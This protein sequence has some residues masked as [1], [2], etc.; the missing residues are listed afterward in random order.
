MGLRLNSEE[1]LAEKATKSKSK[2][3]NNLV[4]YAFLSPWIIGF[5]LFSGF[6]ILV[7]FFLSLTEWNLLGDIKFIG[8]KNYIEMF[9]TGSRFWNTLKVTLIYVIFGV[10]AS[11]IWSLFL[12]VLLNMK[13]KG[14]GIF[15]FIFFIPAVTPIVALVFSFQ[16]MLH[17]QL[18]I[19]NY[20]LSIMGI[21]GPNWLNSTTWAM[22][23]VI[24]ITLFTYST[25]QMMLIFSA[26][27]KDVPKEL[28][29]AC[30]I[31][32]A[33]FFKKFFNVT[34]PSISPILLFNLVISCVNIL[35]GSFSLIYPLTNGGP[36]GATNVLSLD[37]YNNAFKLFR[38]GY[39]SALSVVLFAIIAI[40]SIVQFKLSSKWVYYEN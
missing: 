35:N 2:Q 23:V 22:P 19:V 21:D 20:I 29:E 31:D 1:N 14:I 15:E 27:L 17:D 36:N 10:L 5:I 37:I 38:M 8:L 16:L 6:P 34:L 39:A 32:G 30:D 7:S 25:G 4:A 40:F 9:M 13:V 33:G 26:A 28:Y 18:G 11:V 12:A 24:F 3:N